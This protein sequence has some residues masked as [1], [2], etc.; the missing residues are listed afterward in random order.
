MQ[1]SLTFGLFRDDEQVGFARVVT[2]YA[3]F[4]YLAD[5]L[6]LEPHRGRGLGKWMMEVVFWHADFQDLGGGC[7]QP[8]A[9]MDCSANTVCSRLR[10]PQT[11]GV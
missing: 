5:V 2:D 10:R 8:G 9:R 1:T 4:G 3:T 11:G 6:V 7:L